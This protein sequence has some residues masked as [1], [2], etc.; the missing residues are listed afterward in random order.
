MSKTR[1]RSTK[2]SKSKSKCNKQEIYK[3]NRRNTRRCRMRGG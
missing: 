3:Y 2:K 1:R